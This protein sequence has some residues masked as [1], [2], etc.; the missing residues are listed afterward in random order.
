[1]RRVHVAVLVAA[2]LAGSALGLGGYTFAY[3]RGWS[4]LTDDPAACANCHVMH[5]QHDAWIKGSHRAVATCNDCHVPHDFLGKWYMKARNGFWHSYYF[6]SGTFHEPI[7]ATPASRA[8]VGA[9]CRR[10]HE[11]V[12]L[13]MGMPSHAGSD[14][15]SCIRCHSSVGHMELGATSVAAGG[16]R[17]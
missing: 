3:A 5:E 7:R 17:R 6:T 12:V 14:E 4:Y 9:N 8:V 15:I 13:A 16:S 10:C 1:M 2:V 11:A